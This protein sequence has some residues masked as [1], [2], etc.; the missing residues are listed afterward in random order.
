MTLIHQAY[1]CIAMMQ[2][3]MRSWLCSRRAS[4]PFHKACISTTFCSAQ[5]SIAQQ[6]LVTSPILLKLIL[7]VVDVWLV[8]DILFCLVKLFFVHNLKTVKITFHSHNS[9]LIF[10]LTKFCFKG[11][12]LYHYLCLLRQW[13]LLVWYSIKH[14]GKRLPLK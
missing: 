14:C 5:I 4:S 6:N 12:W 3:G 10:C 9:K 7:N 8:P 13:T 1:Y 2:F 11:I